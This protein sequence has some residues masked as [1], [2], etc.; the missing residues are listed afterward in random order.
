MSKIPG[1]KIRLLKTGKG[2]DFLQPS[3]KALLSKVATFVENQILLDL[4]A[5]AVEEG[6]MK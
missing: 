2:R 6:K 5:Q 3:K 1:E 4:A